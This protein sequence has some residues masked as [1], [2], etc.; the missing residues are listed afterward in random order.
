MDE[1]NE[2]EEKIQHALDAIFAMGRNKHGRFRY[3]FTQAARDFAVSKTT[4]INRSCGRKSRRVA[5]SEQ[6]R[7]TPAQE[8]LLTEWIKRCGARGLGLTPASV[9]DAASHI[10][11]QSLIV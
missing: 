3:S 8:N 7:L 11:G 2:N 10:A 1:S 5:S 6:Q 4:L 9:I